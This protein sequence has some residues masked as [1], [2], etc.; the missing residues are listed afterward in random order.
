MTAYPPVPVHIV[1]GT[2]N[3]LR[4][5]T[6]QQ[7]PSRL[8]FDA[9]VRKMK[10]QDAAT[11]NSGGLLPQLQYLMEHGMDILAL[12]EHVTGGKP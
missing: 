3:Y 9:L 12:V 6:K 8:D 7:T 11:I 5:V 1:Q 10:S 4:H 2:L